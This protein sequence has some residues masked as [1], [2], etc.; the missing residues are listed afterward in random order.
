MQ[1]NQSGRRSAFFVVVCAVLAATVSAWAPSAA[2][3]NGTHTG[4]QFAVTEGGAATITIPIQVPRGIGGLEPQLSLNYSSSAG[5]GLLGIGWTLSGPS[6]ITRCG[7]TIALDNERGAVTFASSDR[8]C[9]DGQRLV[10]NGAT[11]DS[12]YGSAGTVYWTE[13]ESFSRITAVG[14]Y[15]TGVPAGFKVETK[16]GLIM[17]FGAITGFTGSSDAQTLTNPV[18]GGTTTI[19]RWMLKRISDRMPVPNTVEFYYCAREVVGTACLTTGAY[20]GSNVLHYIRYTNRG[21][22]P[23]TNAVMFGYESREDRVLKF[24]A[25][26]SQVQTQRMVSITTYLGF[27]SP[28]T[29]GEAVKRYELTYEPLKDAAGAWTRATNVSRLSRVQELRGG[30]APTT[31]AFAARSA[32]DALPPLDFTYATDR[33]YGKAVP[34]TTSGGTATAAAPIEQCG[35]YAGA[36]RT[37]QMC[38]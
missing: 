3:A 27:A 7:K 36:N 8:F 31:P 32:D 19:N 17:E 14:A 2:H 38:R 26:A 30:A 23:G 22:T 5:N 21:S 12:N 20:T 15:A 33:I 13:R 18:A 9:L 28:A 24:Q 34:Q 10:S 1:G 4:H 25:G 29:P 11:T 35:G 6:A 16:S 37:S